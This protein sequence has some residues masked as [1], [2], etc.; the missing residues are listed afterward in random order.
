M[1]KLFY[2]FEVY[3]D[4]WLVV[5]KD[6]NQSKI[7]LHSRMNFK[8]A[9]E[10]L[11]ASVKDYIFIGFNNERYDKVMLNYLLQNIN[12]PV[13]KQCATMYDM[14]KDIVENNAYY[15][16]VMAD[17]F[18][19]DKTYEMDVSSYLGTGLGAKE[20]ACRLHHPLLET[21]PILPHTKIETQEQIST[22]TK[23]CTND[24]DIVMRIYE[25]VKDEMA[26]VWEIIDYFNLDVSN[27]NKTVGAL[28]E[29]ALTD[30][31]LKPN[32]PA[33]F[34]YKPPVEFNFKTQDFKDAE[35]TYKGLLLESRSKF[36]MEIEIG[37]MS[38]K[39]GLGGIHGAVP[40]SSY[41]NLIDID[42]KQYYP[43]QID[44]YDQLPNTVVDRTVMRKMITDKERYGEAGDPKEKSV[45]K[46]INSVFGRMGF[47][48]SKLYAPDKLYSVT[49]TGQ[50]LLLR[51]VE[52]LTEKGYEV[53]YLNTDGLTIIDNGTED[54]IDIGRAWAEEFGFKLK[55]V[56]FKKAH[57]RDVNNFIV[58]MED[59][60]VKRKGDLNTEPKTK[61]SSFA[62]V[63][64]EAVVEHLLCD[65]PIRDFI[66]SRN[67]LRDFLLYHKY[68]HDMEVYLHSGRGFKRLPNVVR[69]VLVSDREN[70]IVHKKEG[71]DTYENRN[72]NKNVKLVPEFKI[73]N[74]EIKF[75]EEID[76]ERYVTIAYDI[77]HKVTG[78]DV[79]DNPYVDELLE[80]LEGLG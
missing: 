69:Y 20:M 67:D 22:L 24:V 53:V 62:R 11:G 72:H 2:D 26:T 64:V 54:Y 55:F 10:R 14:S 6:E 37:N 7:V 76:K 15:M 1:K 29:L 45:K 46:A 33:R 36:N 79:E 30:P 25:L 31:T 48:N 42:A 58:E 77:L 4:F 34:R 49:I 78:K 47:E 32:P 61:R 52:D 59:G 73:E 8:P 63:A 41:N 51:L 38:V 43:E 56:N 65:T 39:L 18:I 71:K 23:Y 40:K 68:N 17:N 74:G 5:F 13:S 70:A 60:E 66:H 21:L 9:L 27:C 12:T 35:E 28:V 75:I 16:K 50:L 57:Y 80:E 3:P 44:K 19:K